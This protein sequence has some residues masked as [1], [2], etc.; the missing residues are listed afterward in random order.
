MLILWG[1]YTDVPLRLYY[2]KNSFVKCFVDL[3]ARKDSCDWMYTRGI[4]GRR[5]VINVG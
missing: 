4:Y 5:A 2:K 1:I 3:L